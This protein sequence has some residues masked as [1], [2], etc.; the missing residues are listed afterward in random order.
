MSN[1]QT[2]SNMY[3]SWNSTGVAALEHGMRDAAVD[4]FRR[5]LVE[6]RSRLNSSQESSTGLCN[7]RAELPSAE[8]EQLHITEL[9]DEARCLAETHEGKDAIIPDDDILSLPA[10][11]SVPIQPL[12]WESPRNLFG[13]YPR[14]FKLSALPENEADYTRPLVVL[15]YNLA[16]SHHSQQDQGSLR[17]AG[18]LYQSAMDIMCNSWSQHDFEELQCLLLAVANNLGHIHSHLMN[19]HETRNCLHLVLDLISY[20]SDEF[21]VPEEDY[22]LFYDSVYAFLDAPELC[23]APAA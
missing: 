19:F 6:M 10:L 23:I 21:Q 17:Q 3:L 12:T 5:A 15:L 14:A 20:P 8:E 22:K 1:S 16:L 7:R 11:E 2:T 18:R 13:F 9:K 4:T